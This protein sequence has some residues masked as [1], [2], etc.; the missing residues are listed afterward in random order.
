MDEPSHGVASSPVF[1]RRRRRAAYYARGSPARVAAASAQSANPHDWRKSWAQAVY[2]PAAGRG[3]HS[4]GRRI[5]GGSARVVE[6]GRARRGA[7]SRG[8]H[9]PT[10]P[11]LDR[12]DHFGLAAPRRDAHVARLCRRSRRGIARSACEQRGRL[13]RS[14][15]SRGGAGCDHQSG[16]GATGGFGFQGIGPG[17]YVD[18]TAGRPSARQAHSFRRERAD[19]AAGVGSASG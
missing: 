9:G 15:A 5:P 17:K 11:D 19:L 12:V 16:R 4:G 2:P 13:D 14:A 18:R 6:R 8:C 3:A 7:S 10:R 1:P